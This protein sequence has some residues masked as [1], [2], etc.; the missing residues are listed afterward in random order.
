MTFKMVIFS[1][2]S[3]SNR[4]PLN[5]HFEQGVHLVPRCLK[6]FNNII[7]NFITIILFVFIYTCKKEIKL[8]T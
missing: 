7:I 3:H 2:M 4:R 5:D 1:F 8:I 6:N